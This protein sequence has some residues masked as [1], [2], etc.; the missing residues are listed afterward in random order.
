MI[1]QDS[2]YLTTDIINSLIGRGLNISLITGRLVTRNTPLSRSVEVRRII[3]YKRNS[4]SRRLLSW[5]IGFLQILYNV[6]IRYRK[7]YLFI[8]TNPPLSTLLPV[9]CRNRFSLMIFDVYPDA[10][11][12]MEI[13]SPNSTLAKLWKSIN[14]KI[15]PR[16]DNIFTLT[17]SM[18]FLIKAYSG[19]K[20]IEVIP[21]WSD[22]K[23]FK[24]L[25]K[26]SNPFVAEHNLGD[27]FV[28]LY[29]G[30]LGVTHNVEIIL[31]L[32][33]SIQ[34]PDIIFLI[35]GEGARRKW[36]TEEIKKRGLNNC[37]I[38]PLQPVDKIPYSFASADLAIVSLGKMASGVSIPSKTFNFMSAGLPL[39]CIAGEDSE[40]KK[41]VTKYNNGGCFS[42]DKPSEI[43]TFIE[44]IAQNR[45][46]L[47]LYKANSL[48]ASID[49]TPQ[50]AERIAETIIKSIHNN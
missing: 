2:G 30:N 25:S 8:F 26:S 19:N 31:E 23:F 39:L 13:I 32:A 28:V 15:Y 33:S 18:S 38:L 21:V 14:R 50:N 49:F 16:A 5:A 3:R 42:P 12:Q 4:N 47:Q 17:E 27:M 1:N 48:R 6:K 44:E 11:I 34:N 40:L 37:L 10:L 43:V 22:N 36:L 9:F 7:D 29:S 45:D 24:S 35:I 20:E 46:L 41:L